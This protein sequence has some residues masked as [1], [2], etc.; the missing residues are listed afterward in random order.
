MSLKKRQPTKT[1]IIEAESRALWR[2]IASTMSGALN[3]TETAVAVN[4]ADK[5]TD[6]YLGRY[7]NNR[8]SSRDIHGNK[9]IS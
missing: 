6:A 7:L 5:I 3:V 4:W 1:E 8:E 9:L 2:D